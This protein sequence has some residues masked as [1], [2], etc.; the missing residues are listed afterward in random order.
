M[1]DVTDGVFNV[2]LGRWRCDRCAMG[3][4]DGKENTKPYCC[5][6]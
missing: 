6:V 4:C 5:S 1:G 3:E 2:D